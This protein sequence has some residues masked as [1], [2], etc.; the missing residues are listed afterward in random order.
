MA[1]TEELEYDVIIAG[2]G[3]SGATCALGL[4]NAGLKVALIDKAEFPR[5]KI[6][7][8][9]IPGLAIKVLKELDPTFL[10]QF[11]TF[12]KKVSIQRTRFV[13]SYGAHTTKEWTNEAYNCTRIEFDS[14]LLELVLKH[15]H[16]NFFPNTKINDAKVFDSH[17]EVETNKGL[18]KAKILIA[19]DGAQSLLAKKLIQFTLKKNNYSAAVRVYFKDIK[20]LKEGCNEVFFSKKFKLGYFWIFP[21]DA[22]TANVGFGMLS[23]VISKKSIGLQSALYEVIDEFPELKERFAKAIPLSKT[24]GFGLP[25][26]SAKLKLSG[27]RFLLCGDAASL[28]DPISGD[29]IGNAMLSAKL[30]ADHVI[31]HIS[32]NQFTSTINAEYNHLLLNR[33]GKEIRTN[34]LVL[35]LVQLLP[36]LPHFGIYLLSKKSKSP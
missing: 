28:I 14:F 12:K 9:A 32:K 18:F 30:A 19:C 15:S 27:Q 29:G 22:H 35:R 6:C 16:V 20:D 36:W 11:K 31:K 3:P 4:R 24:E 7:G 5:D 21:I 2:A 1:L 13:S 25:M 23:S 34:T 8:D 10:N 26:A 17:V 33:I